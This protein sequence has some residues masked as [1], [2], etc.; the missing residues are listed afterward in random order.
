MHMYKLG[1][2]AKITTALQLNYISIKYFF[3]RKETLE[4]YSKRGFS[5]NQKRFH[6][7]RFSAI[8]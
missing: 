1:C 3:K 2:I 5:A 8:C 4:Y 7:R 6:T